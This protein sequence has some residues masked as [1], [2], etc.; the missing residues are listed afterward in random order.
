ME[1]KYKGKKFNIEVKRFI[2]I[3]NLTTGLM[4]KRRE[5]AKALLFSFKNPSNFSFTSFFVSF[6]FLMLW[7][8]K[9]N[10]V[11][12]VKNIKPFVWKIPSVKD[13]FSVLE[14]PFNKRYSKILNNLVGVPTGKTFKKN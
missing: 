5:K 3:K 12:N 14:I 11:I 13:Y 2:G 10:N 1:F 7:L 6:P 4:F 8:D 9:D